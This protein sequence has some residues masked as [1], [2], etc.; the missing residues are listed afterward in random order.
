MSVFTPVAARPPLGG[1]ANRLSVASSNESAFKTPAGGEI[2]KVDA[3]IAE[4]G[5]M[6]GNSNTFGNYSRHR[7]A[8]RKHRT[9]A[10][11]EDGI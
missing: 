9:K 11:G 5:A 3:L 4:S 2:R 7:G 10:K 8:L 6:P 1:K